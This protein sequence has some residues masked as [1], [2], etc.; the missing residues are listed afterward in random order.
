[1][2]FFKRVLS[3]LTGIILFCTLCVIGLIIIG[4]IAGSTSSDTV[5]IKPNSVL[6]LKL[7]FPIKDYAGKIEF[8]QY[9]FLNE[10]KKN[11]LFNIIDAINYAATDDNIKGISI[12]NN[13]VDAGITQVKALRGALLKFKESGKFIVAYA[14]VF[15]Q[16]DYYLS[17]VADTIYINPAG[18]MEFKGLYSERLYFKDFQ[19]KSGVKMEVVRLG[20]YKSAVEP[21]LSNE[22]SDNNREQISVYLNAL[23]QDIKQDISVTRNVPVDQLNRIADSL[24]ARTPKLAKASGLV[25]KIAYHDEY[26]HGMKQAIGVEAKKTLEMV[27]ILDYSNYASSKIRD[28]SAKDRI[29][30]IYAQGDIMYGEGDENTIGQGSMN[31]S[32]KKAREDE[33]VKAVVLR[34]NSPGGSALASELI[35]REIELTKQVKPVIVSMGDLA[36]SGGYYIA[37]NAHKIIA[38]PT[39]I[40]GSIGVFGML[41]NGKQ[42]AEN[43][44][45]NA[46]Q[47]ITNANAVTYSFFEPLSDAQRHYIKEGIIDIYDLF[48]T[49]VSDGRNLTREQVEEIAQGR[50]WTGSD[51]IKIGLVD[52]L[53]GLDLALKRA[54]EAAN[55]DSYRI[56]EFPVFE[57]DLDKILRKFGLVKAKET[58]LEEELGAENYKL[59]KEIKAL[60]DKKGVQLLFPFSTEIK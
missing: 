19:E 56:N 32:L 17:S 48:S 58:I 23:W 40:T 2:S 37:S 6:N 9:S 46:E 22:M 53:G 44:G 13:F 3:T 4:V 43:M 30:V 31:A 47:V 24:L 29:A 52:E 55:I 5:K 18:M 34:I 8:K 15:S 27:S 25:D 51:A 33:K 35:W 49:R 26:V 54:A 12:D 41:P 36:A 10:A 16:K 42:L 1:M 28:Y 50:V 20:K 45:I 39:T 14:D 60:T 7:D 11:G 38:E 59:L 21:F 57:K